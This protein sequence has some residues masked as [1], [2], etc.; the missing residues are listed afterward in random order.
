MDIRSKCRHAF[1]INVD[2]GY[3]FI[4]DM[5]V[6]EFALDDA[7]ID[8][9]RNDNPWLG[10]A[11]QSLAEALRLAASKELD[12]EF[13]ELVSGYRFRKNTLGSFVDIYIYDNLSSG[14]GYSVSIAENL[15]RLLQN[16]ESQLSECDCAGAC[17]KCLT[18]YRNQNIQG[19]LDRFAALDLLK[20]GLYGDIA[21]ELTSTEQ[22]SYIAPLYNILKRS[23]CNLTSEDGKLTV[24]RKGHNKVLTIY[25][26]MWAAQKKDGFIFVSSALIKYAKPYAVQE[27]LDNI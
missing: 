2:L 19:Q 7:V 8:T 18:H 26:A 12:I 4:T 24:S 27:I 16:V 15:T 6:L 23:G 1:P 22:L 3:D 20:W 9:R 10:R 13:T 11:A 21:P 17:Q 5:L 25:P 14:A